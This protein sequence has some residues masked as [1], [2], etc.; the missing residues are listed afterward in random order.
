MLEYMGIGKMHWQALYHAFIV[1]S[2]P[3]EK[4]RYRCEKQHLK[5]SN[6][7]TVISDTLLVLVHSK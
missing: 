3:L 1:Q 7:A 4:D 6:I 2:L 5:H